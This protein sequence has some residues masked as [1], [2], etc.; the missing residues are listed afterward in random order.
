MSDDHPR[1]QIIE[2]IRERRMRHLEHGVIYRG[3]FVVA[4][5]TVLLAGLAMVVLP[6]PA[7]IVI[8][9]GL[10]M[11][12]LEFAWAENLLEKALDRVEAAKRTAGETSPRQRILTGI[13]ITLGI[14]AAVA[15]VIIYDVPLL[16]V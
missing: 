12:A 13:A 9:I 7:L 1:S 16:P 8:P 10:T 11:L 15:V 4:G 3:A 14:A 6:G 5:F 2:R